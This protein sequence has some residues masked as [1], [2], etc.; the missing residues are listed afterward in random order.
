MR[1][2]GLSKIRRLKKKEEENTTS[3]FSKTIKKNDSLIEYKLERSQT[4]YDQVSSK[5]VSKWVLHKS[6]VKQE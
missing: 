6:V 4:R 5:L 3:Y 1:K 2:V